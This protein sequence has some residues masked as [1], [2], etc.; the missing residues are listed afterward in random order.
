MD[1]PARAQS[2]RT[3]GL[4]QTPEMSEAAP[5]HSPPNLL[6]ILVE[7]EQELE[8]VHKTWTKMTGNLSNSLF[9]RL[10]ILDLP[11]K[12]LECK[13]Q[14]QLIPPTTAKLWPAANE[15]DLNQ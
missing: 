1:A 7:P 8:Y 13:V 5:V 15:A 6:E 2:R 3:Q 10:Y 4:R 9:N 12:R 14:K 11:E